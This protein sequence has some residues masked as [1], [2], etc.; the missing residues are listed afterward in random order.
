M[1]LAAPHILAVSGA[2]QVDK[3]I[4]GWDSTVGSWCRLE[5]HC[6]LGEDVQVKV[7]PGLSGLL[8]TRCCAT[9]ATLPCWCLGLRAARCC[10]QV[11]P[12][13]QAACLPASASGLSRWRTP[14]KCTCHNLP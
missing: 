11:M 9:L 12:C 4:I 13:Q 6:V 1:H 7:G 5:N 8:R 2:A 10:W 14:Q 3:S